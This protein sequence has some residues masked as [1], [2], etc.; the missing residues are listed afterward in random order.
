MR[1]QAARADAQGIDLRYCSATRQGS[2]C[3]KSYDHPRLHRDE[4]REVEWP[5][6]APRSHR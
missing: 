5:R 6:L 2:R 1:D 4:Q 3:D